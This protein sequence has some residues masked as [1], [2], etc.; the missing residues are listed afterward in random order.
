MTCRRPALRISRGFTLV[1]LMVALSGGLFLSMTVFALSRD[2]PRFYQRENRIANANLAGLMGF[3]RLK[4]DI[5]RASYMT[6]PNITRDPKLCMPPLAGLPPMMQTMAGL[7]I[8]PDTPPLGGNAAMAANGVAPDEIVLPNGSR[9][10][11]ATC[12][13]RV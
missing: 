8:N 5:A 3:E 12:T 7:R 2:T 4:A 9:P 10:A 1:E 13:G 11:P 6:T